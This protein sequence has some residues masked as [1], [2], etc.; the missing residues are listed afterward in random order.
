ME[1][2]QKYLSVWMYL[3]PAAYKKPLI[4]LQHCEENYP[5][6]RQCQKVDFHVITQLKDKN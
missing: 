5:V 2:L 4:L 3:K 6:I 1:Y